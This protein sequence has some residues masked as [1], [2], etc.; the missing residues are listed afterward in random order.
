MFWRKDL[1][2]CNRPSKKKK[3][4]VLFSFIYTVKYALT[5]LMKQRNVATTKCNSSDLLHAFI[6]FLLCSSCWPDSEFKGNRY[7]NTLSKSVQNSR[8]FTVLSC[9]KL[10]ETMW[11]VKKK[12]GEMLKVQTSVTFTQSFFLSCTS[13]NKYS[14]KHRSAQITERQT[15]ADQISSSF[16]NCILIL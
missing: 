8:F 9:L 6:V 1:H 14:F 10:C 2:L 5:R 4:L 13:C 3:T 11:E 15:A 16:W 12:L 7:F